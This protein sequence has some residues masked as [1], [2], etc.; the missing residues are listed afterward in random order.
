MKSNTKTIIK[1]LPL[2]PGVQ[3]L[4]TDSNTTLFALNK[5][6]GIKS[7]PNKPGI[8]KNSLIH[9]PYDL[10]NECYLCDLP[11]GQQIQVYLLNR[12]DSPTSGVILL[13]LDLKLALEIHNLFKNH[14]IQKTYLAIVK[15]IPRVLYSTWRNRLSSE[16]H[17]EKVR[18]QKGGERVAE[19]KFQLVSQNKLLG[20]SLL[21]L[22]P[23]TGFTH[24][25]RVQGSLH[26]HPIL[27]D[28]TYGDFPFNKD[29]QKQTSL[30]RLFLHS[31]EISLKYNYLG[32]EHAFKAKS[33]T[34]K[35]FEDVIQ[36]EPLR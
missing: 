10:D 17:E 8:D 25:L 28:K 31:S 4:N 22:M 30:K 23:I 21:K 9:A 14:K 12:L 2:C 36:L 29:I 1:H 33:E 35:E 11:D 15:G 34:P 6:E 32:K 24:Q 7:H 20:I 18:T 13:C 3:V 5:P 26:K 27:G 16:K 19:T